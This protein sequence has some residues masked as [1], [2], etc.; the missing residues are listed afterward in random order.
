MR[1]I[2]LNNGVKLIYKKTE[3]SLTSFCIG[4]N[5]GADKE[6]KENIGAA[7]AVE[8]MVF[9][10]TKTRSEDEINKKCDEL[11]AFNNAMTNFPYVI[12]YGVCSNE[13]FAEGFEL[14][15]DIVINPTMNFAFDEEMSVI[16]TESR[17]WK[18]DID[19]YCED[20]L[21]YNC[22]N[23]RRMKKIIIGDKED[24]EKIT[25]KSLK[26]F[27]DKYYVGAN[28]TVSVVTSLGFDDV[29]KLA[30][31]NIGLMKSGSKVEYEYNYELSYPQL[32]DK[33][34]EGFTGAKIQYC[35][36]IS[37]LNDDEIESLRIFNAYFGEG[38]SCVLYDNLR[39]KHG[40]VYDVSSEVKN[41]S[42]IKLFTIKASTSKEKINDVKALIDNI[43]KDV[44]SGKVA[45]KADDVK[46]LYK[47]IIRKRNMD[48]ERG[49]IMAVRLTT[50]N[51]MYGDEQKLERELCGR[52]DVFSDIN[53]LA[54]HVFRKSA[55]QIIR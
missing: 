16:K 36:D 13:D 53:D 19:Q 39:T 14:Y 9:K 15:S 3:S 35:F 41:E 54:R 32:F 52:Y 25:L 51:I 4:F 10:G 11:F 2:I 29:K 31:K 18:E 33:A 22:F 12:Y 43:I 30:D 27:Y 49:I 28:C 42:G 48:V 1:S 45:V 40:Y 34:I 6:D 26:E 21:Y 24:V 50:Y 8:H 46:K 23:S 38:V 47:R 7:H 20:E 37:D 44:Q 17:E 55:V 5:A